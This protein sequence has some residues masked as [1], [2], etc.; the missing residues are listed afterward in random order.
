MNTQK[1]MEELR[2]PHAT[3]GRADTE[4]IALLISIVAGF[5]GGWWFGGS[6]LYGIGVAVALPLS[7]VVIVVVI[8][9]VMNR[10]K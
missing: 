9:Y 10:L 2:G 8:S 6:I 4:A 7:L 3:A 5:L 1:T